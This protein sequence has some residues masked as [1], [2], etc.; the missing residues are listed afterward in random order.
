M[1]TH[2]FLVS[3]TSCISDDCSLVCSG[4]LV[5]P[6]VV[7]TAAHCVRPPL[8]RPGD[9]SLDPPLDSLYVIAGTADI[10]AAD[11]G[12]TAVVSRVKAVAFSSYGTNYLFSMDGDVA[13]LELVDCLSMPTAKVATATSDP[14]T[15]ASVSVAGFGQ[16][17]NAPAPLID[18]NGKAR[19][20]VDTLHSANVCRDAYVSLAQGRA[21]PDYST[22]SFRASHQLLSDSFVCLGGDSWQ[23]ACFGDSGGPVAHQRP[24]ESWEILG[25]VSFGFGQDYCTLGPDFAT[26]VSF[27]AHWIASEIGN[28]SMCPGWAIG[29]S[30]V[31]W[32]LPAASQLSAEFNATRCA[33]SEWQCVS[34]ECVDRSNVCNGHDDCR[35]GS[36]ENF[37]IDSVSICSPATPTVRAVKSAVLLPTNVLGGVQRPV[38]KGAVTAC[39]VA[40]ES[41]FQEMEIVEP[42]DTSGDIWD[43]SALVNAC[44]S[45]K[46]CSADGTS[47]LPDFVT[48]SEFCVSFAAFVAFN[49]S[50]VA[51]AQTFNSRF[52]PYCGSADPS[53]TIT[54][55]TSSLPIVTGTITTS[56][57][58]VTWPVTTSSPGVTSTHSTV[59]T[60]GPTPTTADPEVV[61]T[62][63][64]MTTPVGV[65]TEEPTT[66][67]I[68]YSEVTTADSET[69]TANHTTAW[70]T[71]TMPT[72]NT[73]VQPSSARSIKTVLACLL[74]LV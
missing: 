29:R 51:Y 1:A 33:S 28:M 68:M 38:L 25:V 32:P 18:Y 52:H 50:A 54:P 73:T 59:A 24:D 26:R 62:E 43:S 55:V 3:I 31:E 12:P 67:D 23:S 41:V 47:S 16:M 11:W 48:V 27:Y 74:F 57:P 39:A 45:F 72:F 64:S 49:A 40:M 36:D 17:T 53:S 69:T 21:V 10:G 46:T 15:C 37:Q 22:A 19:V 42:K 34:R 44:D 14:G 61:T 9:D 5:A 58:L 66:T 71:F 70:W 30:F 2:P 8:S 7:L 6:N 4:S 13:L 56:A 63:V 20:L 60:S 65:S 35:D